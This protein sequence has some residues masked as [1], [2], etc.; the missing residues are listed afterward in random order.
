[1]L[2]VEYMDGLVSLLDCCGWRL[3]ILMDSKVSMQHEWGSGYDHSFML[4]TI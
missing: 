1:M 2:V 4:Y 3:C